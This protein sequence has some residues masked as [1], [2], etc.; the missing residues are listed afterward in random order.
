M[1]LLS[2]AILATTVALSAASAS[3]ATIVNHSN[4][5]S[6]GTVL[7]KAFEKNFKLEGTSFYQASNCED[8]QAK[9]ENTEDAIFIYN[10]DVGIA[11][12]SKNL[13]CPF[14]GNEN[15]TVFV[16]HSYIDW[17][18][19]TDDPKTLET[20]RAVGVAGVILSEGL[21]NDYNNQ[22]GVDVKFV[23]YGGSKSVLAALIAGDIDMGLIG[24]GVNSPARENGDVVCPVEGN[25]TLGDKYVGKQYPGLAIAPLP[26]VKA[27]YTNSKD[28]AV[29]EA[30]RQA[31][32]T[33]EFS[34]YL[35][36][37]GY[38][39]VLN[40]EE[41]ITEAEVQFA[42]DHLTNVYELYWK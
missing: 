32:Q 30:A 40:T 39:K 11:G 38:R 23:P 28:P 25:P 36:K 12:A 3:A 4:A 41:T 14:E 26:I 16:G 34:A 29:L 9:F 35:K 27:I 31:V 24:H 6:P 19:R 42:G 37:S 18:H 21:V 1:K 8:A 20:S 2:T 22:P 17:C 13:A 10:I 7:A 15:T 33:P 5:A